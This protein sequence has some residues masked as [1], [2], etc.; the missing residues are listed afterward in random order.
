MAF[1]TIPASG[2]GTQYQNNLSQ[3]YT[4]S[5]ANF[6]TS[7]GQ[8]VYVPAPVQNYTSGT[9]TKTTT[10]GGSS[11]STNSNGRTDQE[12]QDYE[13]SK[14][15]EY[16][17]QAMG[18]LDSQ[19]QS[20][21]KNQSNLYTNATSPYDQQVPLIN[22]AAQQ[23]QN[24]IT[25]QQTEAGT[26]EQNALSAARRL[27]DELTSRNRQ[28]FGSGALGSV[29]QAASEVLGRS[30]QEQFGTI[31]NTAGETIQK[32]ATASRDLQEKTN[33]QLQSLELQKQQ[34]LAQ[35]KMWFQERLD[36]INNQRGQVG[37]AK[38]SAKLDTLREYRNRVWQLEDQSKALSNQITTQANTAGQQLYQQYTD[39]NSALTAGV[40]GGQNAVTNQGNTNSN[41]V[42]GLGNS[43][44]LSGAEPTQANILYGNYAGTTVGKKLE[45]N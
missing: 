25:T 15:D 28:A 36:S 6:S 7:T 14:I 45:D 26:Q 31:R 2:Y 22:Q 3:Q 12:Q 20:L 11:T 38:A 21:Y 1:S 9:P 10:S 8:S 23:G 33:A 16:F 35:A 4:P 13:N 5:N 44:T 32:L 41:A 19:E 17:G 24:A 40:Q 37:Q 42:N 39:Y 29:G 30:A 43:N 34:A 18:T 27:Y